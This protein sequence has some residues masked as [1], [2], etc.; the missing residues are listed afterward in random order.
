MNKRERAFLRSAVVFG[1]SIETVP[2]RKTSLWDGDTLLPV[3]VGKVAES[4]IERGYLECVSM[5]QGVEIIRATH[6]AK[7][8]KCNAGSCSYGKFIDE[9]GQEAG[10]C[11]HCDGGIQVIEGEGQ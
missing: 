8:L 4:L 9:D 10:D 5:G 3:T 2:W 6:K 7:A 11:P 1:W